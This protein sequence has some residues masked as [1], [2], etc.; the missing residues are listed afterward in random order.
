MFWVS[1][2]DHIP[3]I[4]KDPLDLIESQEADG[5]NPEEQLQR[6]GRPVHL[7][8]G[9]RRAPCQSMQD[10]NLGRWALF[11]PLFPGDSKETLIVLCD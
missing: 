2:A 10:F 1:D 7:S 3:D 5:V 9:T 4:D 8:R 6:D 11:L